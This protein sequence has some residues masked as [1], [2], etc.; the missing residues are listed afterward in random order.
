MKPLAVFYSAVLVFGLL[1]LVS[2]QGP[3]Q[4]TIV[5]TGGG[6]YVVVYAGDTISVHATA[7]KALE[8][9]ANRAWLNP[10]ATVY[11]RQAIEYR[12]TA[13]GGTPPPAPPPPP[14]V[15]PPAPPPAPPPSPPPPA[16]PPSPPPAPPP[17]PS[18]A[19]GALPNLPVGMTLIGVQDW[20]APLPVSNGG[21]LGA[22]SSASGN[23]DAENTSYGNRSFVAPPGPGW[24]ASVT[25]VLKIWAPNDFYALNPNPGRG[26]H[27]EK[28]RFASNVNARELYLHYQSQMGTEWPGLMRNAQ[29][30]SIWFYL[31]GTKNWYLQ[32]RPSS[33]T[34][35][36]FPSFERISGGPVL[37]PGGQINFHG[38]ATPRRVEL[39]FKLNAPGVADGV[40]RMWV[41]GVLYFE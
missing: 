2:D 30:K 11:V 3:P 20:T 7:H 25:S 37:A 24:D 35:A 38:T 4:V 5:A 16:P 1:G 12:V 14:P 34:N 23:Y 19:P 36:A 15:P 32:F 10:G 22:W 13:I 8:A 18:P 39:Y 27:H 33:Q 17:S 29:I 9:A 26:L 6:Q 31:R 41:D 21:M 40:M 28:Y